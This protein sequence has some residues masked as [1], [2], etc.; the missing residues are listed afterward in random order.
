MRGGHPDNV[1]LNAPFTMKEME[2]QLD[3]CKDS[4]PD[5]DEITIHDKAPDNSS[6]THPPEGFKQAVV[7]K[8]VS[9]AVEQRNQVALPEAR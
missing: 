4:A 9:R 6:K 8:S 2:T 7:G 3:R 1:L 5:P